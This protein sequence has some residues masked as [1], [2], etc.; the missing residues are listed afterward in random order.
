MNEQELKELA[1]KYELDAAF[2]SQLY[3]NLTDKAT[4]EK[5]LRM[6]VAGTLKFD[7]A[8]GNAHINVASVRH[9]VAVNMWNTRKI[10]AERVKEQMEMQRRIVE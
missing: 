7:I 5:A 8:S 10:R 2:V 6:F 3:D 4:I 1:A 9:D